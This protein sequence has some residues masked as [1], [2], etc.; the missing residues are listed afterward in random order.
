MLD[1]A[2]INQLLLARHLHFLAAENLK[3]E[4]DVALFAAAN[5]LQDAVEAFLW[6]AAS[7]KNTKIKE[8]A[9][10]STMFDKISD[11]ITPD[12]LPFRTAIIRLNK[13]RVSSKH[14]GIQPDRDVLTKLG[15]KI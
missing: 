4:R 14:H 2:T 8:R 1:D 12:K 5:L 6:G 7:H 10:L 9:D 15:V 3:S 13:I 11:A